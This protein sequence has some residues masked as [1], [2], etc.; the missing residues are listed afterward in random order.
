MRPPSSTC[1]IRTCPNSDYVARPAAIGYRCDLA[2]IDDHGEALMRSNAVPQADAA[3]GHA[4]R[5]LSDHRTRTKRNGVVL[6]Y[7]L[8]DVEQVLVLLAWNS[9]TG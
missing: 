6:E 1:R 9:F 5:L 3:L 7:G 2:S 4:R 8:A